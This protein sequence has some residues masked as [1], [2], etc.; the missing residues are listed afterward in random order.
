MNTH[1]WVCVCESFYRENNRA[2]FGQ[3]LS[4]NLFNTFEIHIDIAIYNA[5]KGQG[6]NEGRQRDGSR[7]SRVKSRAK[8]YLKFHLQLR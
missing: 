5:R 3:M 8:K 2:E 6:M 1:K 4:R 7:G